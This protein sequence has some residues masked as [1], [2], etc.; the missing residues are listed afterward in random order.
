MLHG[1]PFNRSLWARAVRV[2]APLNSAITPDLRGFGARAQAKSADAPSTMQ[3]MAQ[4]DVA[5]ALDLSCA[6]IAGWWADYPWAAM[7]ALAFAQAFSPLR[8]RARIWP[9]TRP[10]PILRK[11]ERGA[12]KWPAKGGFREGRILQ[13]V[14]DAMLR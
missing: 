11:P 10:Q 6:L 7:T 1:F 5:V 9:D 3:E 14:A 13:R 12:Q 2:T 4:W 8:L